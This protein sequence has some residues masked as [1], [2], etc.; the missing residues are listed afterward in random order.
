MRKVAADLPPWDHASHF[1]RT[2]A[3]CLSILI[4]LF[5]ATARREELA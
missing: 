5:L 2:A 4:D 3:T 1:A